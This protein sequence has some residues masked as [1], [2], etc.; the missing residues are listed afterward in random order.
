M[1]ERV[2][3]CFCCFESFNVCSLDRRL[4]GSLVFVTVG[5]PRELFRS[6]IPGWFVD[7][8]NYHKVPCAR[9]ILGTF[10]RHDHLGRYVW[11]AADVRD[12]NQTLFIPPHHWDSSAL[13]SLVLLTVLRF[14]PICIHTSFEAYLE[15]LFCIQNLCEL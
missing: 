11:G 5:A 1:F 15:I 3:G 14:V 4:S 7:Y 12:C 13:I 2:G 9:A 10:G 8:Y 6:E